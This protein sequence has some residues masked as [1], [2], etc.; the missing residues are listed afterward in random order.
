ML[1]LG[2]SL[3]SPTLP[4]LYGGGAIPTFDLLDFNGSSSFG[5][6]TDEIVGLTGT[7]AAFGMTSWVYPH[8]VSSAQ[9]I[10]IFGRSTDFRSFG[11]DPNGG[12]PRFFMG[13]YKTGVHYKT[14]L[15][16]TTI[17]TNIWY[18]VSYGGVNNGAQM[19]V[20][21]VYTNG[22][23]SDANYT[24]TRS[25]PSDGLIRLG[26]LHD[27]T[28]FFDGLL[29]WP[30]ISSISFTG[31]ASADLILRQG[32]NPYTTSAFRD[33][34]ETLWSTRLAVSVPTNI[35]DLTDT[36]Y[37][38]VNTDI[39]K[40]KESISSLPPDSDYYIDGGF[41]SD[42]SKGWQGDAVSAFIDLEEDY[43]LETEIGSGDFALILTGKLDT[44]TG[45]N[46]ILYMGE[47]TS[48]FRQFFH[49]RLDDT[50]P[51][52]T[53]RASGSTYDRWAFSH[54]G[55]IGEVFTFILSRTGSTFDAWLG[56][57]GGT[58]EHL[59]ETD[60]NIGTGGGIHVQT[61][62]DTI[63][64]GSFNLGRSRSGFAS[65]WWN[66]EIYHFALLEGRTLTQAQAEDL[67]NGQTILD[68]N[69]SNGNYIADPD[70]IPVQIIPQ[71]DVTIAGV[72]YI[73]NY[74]KGKIVPKN[75]GG[76]YV[77]K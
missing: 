74:S 76:T 33:N 30:L 64:N 52:L 31:P 10:M 68:V 35:S 22:T 16:D 25:H 69:T 47:D 44:V 42:T 9:T 11:I 5:E 8:D 66:G 12:D 14:Y 41:P 2:Y 29:A 51:Q 60:T 3:D 53:F 75:E 24:S 17:S 50:V 7:G 63:P 38:L 59:D 6:N 28:E 49:F 48:I 67:Y 15:H 32:S 77:T 54:T 37:D 73:T 58:L 71:K 61:S 20:N 55:A 19:T 43:D 70:N 21:G 13:S 36:S 62:F 40:V 1:Q 4:F 18:L 45:A 65:G 72:T 39:D 26:C 57:D 23:T 46:T 34:I 27:D 56:I